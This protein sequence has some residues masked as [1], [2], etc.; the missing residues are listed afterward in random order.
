VVNESA[1]HDALAPAGPQAAGLAELSWTLLGGAAVIFVI[2][3]ALL[4]LALW[5]RRP[6]LS[7]ARARALVLGGGVVIPAVVLVALVAGSVAVGRTTAAAPPADALWIEVTGWRWW[8]EVRY[9]HAPGAVT[10][11]E[12]HVP[13]G[14][15]V[16]LRLVSRDVI[17]SFWVPTLQGKMDLIPGIVNT[18]W[19]TAERPGTYRGLCAEFCG[20]QHAKMAFLVVAQPPAQFAAWLAQQQR[21]APAPAEGPARRGREVFR[22]ACRECHVVRG[23]PEPAPGESRIA[24]EPRPAPDLTHLASRRTL[25]AATWPNTRGHL[26]G[27]ILDPQAAKPGS[28]MPPTLLPPDE[29]HALLAYLES[30]E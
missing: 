15:P 25:A 22:L 26:G 5:R 18:A 1:G 13:V 23:M 16:A 6:A 12:I 20:V 28:L 21:A 30:L 10:A 7:E 17:H 27:W 8:W 24:V 19:F 9:P 3:M 29:L 2:V 14:R 4:A 11:N